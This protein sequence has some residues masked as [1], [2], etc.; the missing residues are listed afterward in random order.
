MVVCSSAGQPI[1]AIGAIPWFTETATAR[2]RTGRS[3]T[4]ARSS[5]CWIIWTPVSYEVMR[6]TRERRVWL[7]FDHAD[8]E[9]LE[10]DRRTMRLR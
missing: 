1:G 4:G 9:G 8:D 2:A 10:F 3:R 7:Y 5:C 6:P